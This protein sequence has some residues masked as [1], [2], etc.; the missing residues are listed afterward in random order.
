VV[1]SIAASQGKWWIAHT[2]AR[3]EKAFA[4]DLHERGIGYFL[5]MLRRTRVS[6]GRKRQFMMPLFPSYVFFCG[7]DETRYIALTGNRLCQVIPVKDQAQIRAELESIDHAI[8]AGDLLDPYPF[9]AVGRHCRI[10]AGPFQGIEGVVV[11][12]GRMARIVLQVTLLGQG[13]A[14]DIETDLLEAIDESPAGRDGIE[15]EL[16]EPRMTAP[17]ISDPRTVTHGVNHPVNHAANHSG[18][19]AAP[20][21]ASVLRSS[22]RN[23]QF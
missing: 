7:D 19:H 6:G 10:I 5:P 14:L 4:W 12:R 21:S 16:S 22:D 8:R 23:S 11:Q 17:R 20:I 15:P 2:K 3:F 13:V 1:P 18:N 9:A